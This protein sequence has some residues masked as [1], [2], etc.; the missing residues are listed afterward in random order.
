VNHTFFPLQQLLLLHQDHHAE[1]AVRLE[2]GVPVLEPAASTAT[3]ATTTTTGNNNIIIKEDNTV[4]S[5]S[6]GGR[7]AINLYGLPRSFKDLVLPSL[8]KHVIRTNAPYNCDYFIHYYNVTLEEK[9]KSGQGGQ[10]NPHDI[11]DVQSHIVD[12]AANNNNNN[13]NNNSS[14]SSNSSFLRRQPTIAFKSHTDKEFWDRRN[15]TLQ[16]VRNTKDSN[17]RYY[18]FPWRETMY[19]HPQTTDNV[20]FLRKSDSYHATAD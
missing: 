20:S 3:T 9:G 13:P 16:K 1:P 2:G 10:I 8:V 4:S 12:A 6:S 5:S 18:Y 7:C 17:G 15:E 14:S 11:L 19:R